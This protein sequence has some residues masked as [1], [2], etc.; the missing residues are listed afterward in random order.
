MGIEVLPASADRWADVARVMQTPGDPEACWCQVF[1]HP[2][3][4]WDA[5]PVSQNTVDL[6][7]LVEGGLRPGLV[8][9]DDGEPVGWC[10]VAPLS[11]LVRI[12]TSPYF[13]ALRPEGEDLSGRWA[14]TCFVVT[15]AAR[16]SGLVDVLLAAA[17]AH[18]R[19]RGATSVEGIPLDTEAAEHVTPDELFGGTLAAFT[20]AGF[21]ETGRLGP[22][23][24][25]AVRHL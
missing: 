10:S 23:R 24:V 4:D 21:S 19:D 7:A 1:R 14:V 17:V 5:R 8:A 12:T 13:A 20:S 16:G 6:R 9:Y 22:D 25:L 2:R 18:A 11:E 15:E 3:E